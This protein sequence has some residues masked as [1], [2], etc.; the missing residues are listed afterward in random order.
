MLILLIS[1][2]ACLIQL[3]MLALLMHLKHGSIS[4]GSAKQLCLILQPI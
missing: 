2:T 1:R 4:F 3:L